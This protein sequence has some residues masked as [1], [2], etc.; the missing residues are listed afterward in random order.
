MLTIE[1]Y[2]GNY[3]S[4]TKLHSIP[5]IYENSWGK[6]GHV[7]LHWQLNSCMSHSFRTN[8]AVVLSSH[9]APD[10]SMHVRLGRR[11][12]PLW[13]SYVQSQLYNVGNSCALSSTAH[14]LKLSMPS[15]ASHLRASP[16]ATL[17]AT[18]WL[19]KTTIPTPSSCYWWTELMDCTLSH[20]IYIY[21]HT[22]EHMVGY[23][24]T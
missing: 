17:Q 16:S 2:L 19:W 8:S 11:K 12:R 9:L 7:C 10:D 15:Q 21:I 13:F 3:L 22:Y 23:I 14:S 6:T 5:G 18:G 4:S 1:E 24:V 20:Y